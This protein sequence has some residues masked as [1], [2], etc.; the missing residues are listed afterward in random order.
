MA[1]W[2]KQT[3][4]PN[5]KLLIQI[6]KKLTTERKYPNFNR[7]KA[8][9]YCS[10]EEKNFLLF[11][12]PKVIT[13]F[14]TQLNNQSISGVGPSITYGCPSITYRWTHRL[15]IMSRN[16]SPLKKRENDLREFQT[17]TAWTQTKK[18]E[19]MLCPVTVCTTDHKIGLYFFPRFL[20]FF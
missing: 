16:R 11:R 3:L 1:D 9:S 12:V 4:I 18:R 7:I 8:W 17:I 13:N 10:S 19:A 2:L 6:Q 20:H 15:Y 5:P 14:Q